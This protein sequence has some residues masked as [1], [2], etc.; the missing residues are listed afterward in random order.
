MLK[1]LKE[2]SMKV[3]INIIAAAKGCLN[4]VSAIS[5]ILDT[6]FYVIRNFLSENYNTRL[7]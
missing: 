5:V 6:F 4:V 2:M 3:N 7:D 1:R